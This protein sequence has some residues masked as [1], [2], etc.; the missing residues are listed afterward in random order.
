MASALS[1]EADEVDDN[2]RIVGYHTPAEVARGLFGT[3][4][5]QHLFHEPP[6][7][8]VEVRLAPAAAC[9]YH[10]VPGLN[11]ARDQVGADVAGSTNDK[12]SHVFLLRRL[13]RGFPL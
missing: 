13:P 1:G 10:S 9:V 7:P 2:V 8:V 5:H 12:D 4:V 6:D 11:K 3:T